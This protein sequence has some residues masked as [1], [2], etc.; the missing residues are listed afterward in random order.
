MFYPWSGVRTVEPERELRAAKQRG[1]SLKKVMIRNSFSV[2]V[3]NN[4]T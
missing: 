3:Y 1:Q 2:T 4:D